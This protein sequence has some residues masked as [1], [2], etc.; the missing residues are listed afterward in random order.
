[1]FVLRILVSSL[2]YTRQTI[3]KD[4]PV[5]N[6]AMVIKSWCYGLNTCVHINS[7]IEALIPQY[8]IWQWDL[9]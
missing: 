8:D 1:M 4:H 3:R 6:R 2:Q 9:W 7:Y 5:H